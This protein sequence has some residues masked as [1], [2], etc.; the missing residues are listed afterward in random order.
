MDYFGIDLHQKHSEICGIDGDGRVKYQERVVTTEA[1]LRRVFGS[2]KHLKM[3]G[4]SG[5]KISPQSRIDSLWFPVCSAFRGATA[6][7]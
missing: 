2:L 7:V 3:L 4:N 5:P 1:G 6:L